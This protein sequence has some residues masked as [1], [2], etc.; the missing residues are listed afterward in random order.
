MLSKGE[1]CT[2]PA[3]ATWITAK[4]EQPST[5]IT[6]ASPG[7]TWVSL[8]VAVTPEPPSRIQAATVAAT[9]IKR[10]NSPEEHT[11]IVALAEEA[12]DACCLPAAWMVTKEESKVLLTIPP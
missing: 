12:P 9:R 10:G 5:D 6:N 8:T 1:T 2:T 3:E 4:Y 11:G 7:C